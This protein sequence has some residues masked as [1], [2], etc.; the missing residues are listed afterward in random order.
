MVSMEFIFVHKNNKQMSFVLV[1][2]RFDKSIILK[3]EVNTL[4]GCI[5]LRVLDDLY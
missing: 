5:Q 4:G 2:V 1:W 3:G